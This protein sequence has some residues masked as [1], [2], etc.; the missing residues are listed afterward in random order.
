MVAI[1]GL[2][3]KRRLLPIH[4]RQILI[5]RWTPIVLAPFY[6]DG[7]AAF[8]IPDE[9]VDN[10]VGASGAGVALLYDGNIFGPDVEARDDVDGAFIDFG[11]GDVA[12]VG[13]PPIACVAAHLLLS[14]EF[15]DAVADRIVWFG[16][17]RQAAFLAAF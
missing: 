8:H 11:V 12:G 2:N 6:L 3:G 4:T 17:R 1:D 10:R 9:Q 16:Q 15:S 14:D 7:F 5:R 13:A